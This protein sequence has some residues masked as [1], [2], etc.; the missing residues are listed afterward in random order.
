MFTYPIDERALAHARVVDA[1]LLQVTNAAD[2]RPGEVV[3][4]HKALADI[5]RGFRVLKSE[6]E[7][8]SIYHRLPERIRAHT[9]ICFGALILYRVMRTRLRASDSSLLPGRAL[10]R[11]RSS[12]H[13]RVTLSETSP[14]A[15]LS[16]ICQQETD[17]PSARTL[18]KPTLHAQLTLLQWSV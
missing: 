18:K 6:I 2:S 7:I 13:H 3:S 4:R 1:K 8:G 15:G 16:T 11:L 12:E 10:S 9:T 14:V 17:I 5:E